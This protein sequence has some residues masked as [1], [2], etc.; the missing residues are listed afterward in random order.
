MQ[1][2][3]ASA[4]LVCRFCLQTVDIK[5]AAG[6]FTPKAVLEDL[7]GRMS[8]LLQVPVRADENL[9]EYTCR[10]CKSATLAVEKKLQELRDKAQSSYREAEQAPGRKRTKDTSSGPGIS[11]AT[12]TLQPPHKRRQCSGKRLFQGVFKIKTMHII[13]IIIV[14]HE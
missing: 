12:A 8:R 3:M 10:G 11:P 4:R 1:L 13:I 6:L 14:I 7:P 5:H 2:A 9:S